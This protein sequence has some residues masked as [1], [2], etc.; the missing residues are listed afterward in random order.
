M[1][2]KST[3]LFLVQVDNKVHVDQGDNPLLTKVEVFLVPP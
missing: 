3:P 1:I 2:G